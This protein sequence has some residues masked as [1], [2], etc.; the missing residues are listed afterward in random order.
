MQ[1]EWILTLAAGL[2]FF[3]YGM[4]LMGDGLEKAAGD[5][6]GGIVDALTSNR[7]K[8]VLV[9]AGVTAIVQSSSAVTVMVIGFINAGIMTLFQAVGVIMGANIGTTITAFIISLEDINASSMWFLEFLKPSTLAPIA[10]ALGIGMLLFID[11]KKYQNI[12]TVLAGFGFLFIGLGMMESSMSFLKDF[13][14]FQQAI[15]SFGSNPFLGVLVGAGVTAIIQSSSASVGILQTVAFNTGMPFSAAVPVILGQNI[16]TCVTALLSSVGA[17]KNAK[18]AAVVHLLFNVVGT[19]LFL[20]LVYAFPLSQLIPFW[21]SAASRFQIAIFHL[22]FNVSNTVI[23]LPFS[24]WLVRA[25]TFLVPGKERITGANSLDERLIATPSLALGQAMKEVGHMAHIAR[26]NVVLSFDMLE[27]Q[28][29]GR[30]GKIDDN[31]NAVD[32]MEAN[33]TQYLVK[34]AERPLN[35]EDNE[36]VSMLFHIITDIERIGDHAYNIAEGAQSALKD[37]IDT[38]SSA[39]EELGK[40]FAATREIMDLAVAAYENHDIEAARKIQPCEDVIDLMKET[41]RMRHVDRLTKQKCNIKS[42]VLFLDVIN[43]LERIADHCSNIG[44]AVEQIAN[45]QEVGYDQHLYMKDL[46]LNKTDEYKQMYNDYLKKYSM[47]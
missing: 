43:N 2:G 15:A 45:P 8:G 37:G 26:E 35:D 38:S 13:E 29:A 20:I 11:K 16:G 6:L 22:I 3:M 34:I 10:A 47:I 40:M 4:K 7:I 1:W 17:N 14:G 12:G 46:H 30:M 9:G 27:R 41:F 18:R 39:M 25:A 23:L 24:G 36:N 19:I 44:L 42:G 21:D 33:T 28:N 32:E 5:R 31:E